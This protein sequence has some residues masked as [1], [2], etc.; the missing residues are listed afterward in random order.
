MP[1]VSSST[2]SRTSTGALTTSHTLSAEAKEALSAL[3]SS[4]TPRMVSDSR[5]TAAAAA[6]RRGMPVP[7]PVAGSVAPAATTA[8]GALRPASWLRPRL[9][10]A[11]CP[12]GRAA[13]AISASILAISSRRSW[14]RP[15]PTTSLMP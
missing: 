6:A 7:E 11:H 9:T 13:P 4:S 8:I 10:A 12:V 15:Y 3:E 1:G 5:S 2:P 14:L